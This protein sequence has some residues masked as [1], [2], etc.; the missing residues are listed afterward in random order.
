MLISPMRSPG[1]ESHQP[2]SQRALQDKVREYLDRYV[3]SSNTE[4]K[5]RGRPRKKP[6][7]E[8]IPDDPENI[9]RIIMRT[10]ALATTALFALG[11]SRPLRI[12]QLR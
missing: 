7:L 8:P 5:R 3:R 12:G 9:M 4:R 11:C 1:L 6:W 2:V 10:P